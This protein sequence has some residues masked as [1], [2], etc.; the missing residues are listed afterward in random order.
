MLFIKI[1]VCFNNFDEQMKT[2]SSDPS[3]P[4]HFATDFRTTEVDN[5]YP[6]QMLKC[7]HIFYTLKLYF[8]SFGI[9]QKCIESLINWNAATSQ[10]FKTDRSVYCLTTFGEMTELKANT[11]P[12][13]TKTCLPLVDDIRLIC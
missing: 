11:E 6:H 10:D 9:Q 1:C 4:F 8:M 2:W 12:F 5:R 7:Y 13:T 3:K